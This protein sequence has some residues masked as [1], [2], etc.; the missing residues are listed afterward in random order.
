MTPEIRNLLKQALKIRN[1]EVPLHRVIDVLAMDGGDVSE[2]VNRYRGIRDQ[3]LRR[4]FHYCAE[5]LRA[6]EADAGLRPRWEPGDEADGRTAAKAAP[7]RL[8]PAQ[9][10]TPKPRFR[11][12]ELLAFEMS[13]MRGQARAAKLY[14]DGASKGNPG[15]AAIGAVL[16]TMD[17]RKIAQTSRAI[18]RAT[19][20]IAEYIALIEGM[21]MAERMGV[22]SLFALSDSQLV[23]NQMSGVYKIKNAAI[24]E[25]AREAQQL[26]HRFVKFTISYIQREN[27]TL[28]DA[29]SNAAIK[30][31]NNAQAADQEAR[32]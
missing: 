23:V 21:R 9:S 14:V 2:A 13:E 31:Q 10:T 11:P 32:S 22:S 4:A 16:F 15:Q 7:A 8:S 27:N 19:N 25:K 3:D 28:A 5:L 18:G 20:N 1:S 26:A 17:G 30:A 12:E 24:F 29:L 6:L